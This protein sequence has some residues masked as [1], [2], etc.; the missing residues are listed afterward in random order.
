[1]VSKI[2]SV[3]VALVAL[4]AVG[5]GGSSLSVDTVAQ[6]QA[7]IRA[8]EE[9]GASAVPQAALHLKMAKDQLA[10][11]DK[12]A[13]NGDDDKASRAYGRSKSDAELAVLLAR[14]HAIKTKA[15]QAVDKAN[16]LTNAGP[17]EK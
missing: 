17:G 12:L 11:G 2:G 9:A 1:M 14:H 5:C 15:Q 6:P 13:A 16:A 8:A 3:C 10:Q 4:A 7:E